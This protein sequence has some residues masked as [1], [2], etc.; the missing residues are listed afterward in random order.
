VEPAAGG[1]HTAHAV[2]VHV[3][4]GV[5]AVLEF[6]ATGA[7]ELEEGAAQLLTDISSQIGQFMERR[8][9]E[10]SLSEQ[11][12]ERRLARIIQ[13]GF[14]PK[15]PPV[16]PGFVVYGSSQPAEVVGGD[17]FD[18]VPMPDGHL[19]I[20]IGDVS[21]HG[22]GAALTMGQV[23][24]C[25]RALAL[26]HS[27]PAAILGLCNRRLTED[28]TTDVFAT[29]FFARLDAANRQLVYSN[30]GHWPGYLFDSRGEV[31]A[32]LE[33][34]GLPLGVIAGADFPAGPVVT[35]EPGELVLLIT[36][37]I[38]EATS[39]EGWPFGLER[40]MSVVRATWG[41]PPAE[42]IEA[43]FRTVHEYARHRPKDDIT[44]LV[45]RA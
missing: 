5:S 37:G 20:V 11:M 42:I 24:A 36:D 14:L 28:L 23:R 15:A 25:M 32:V 38:V 19:G 41:A 45:V 2:P 3:G 8:A 44:A 29:L 26:T 34:T 4:K 17:Y 18:F 39:P 43:L 27:D 13:Q 7:R 33:S 10:Q 22:V 31:K 9:A 1:L 6:F 35:M 30:A 40:A 16:L 21:G 12:E